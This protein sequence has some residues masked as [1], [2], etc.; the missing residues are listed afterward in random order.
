MSARKKR[1]PQEVL[2]LLMELKAKRLG[3][4]DPELEE[5]YLDE[6][7]RKWL[8]NIGEKEAREVLK[9]LFQN[10]LEGYSGLSEQVCPFCLLK[11]RLYQSCRSCPYSDHHYGTCYDD[12]SDFEYIKEKLAQ[13]GLR[14][15]KLLP[16]EFYLITISK[17][18]A[19]IREQE[20][21]RFFT[22]RGLEPWFS[23]KGTFSLVIGTRGGLYGAKKT[24]RYWARHYP[25]YGAHEVIELYSLSSGRKKREIC[26]ECDLGTISVE[27]LFGVEEPCSSK[28]EQR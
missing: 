19:P 15:R 28:E 16:P 21:K 12:S 7:D 8:L 24:S 27:E 17:L 10:A 14:P 25:S 18:V 13:S 1:A 4:I 20:G 22:I 9:D 26:S 3:S 2:V 5:L 11:G 23:E 6:K